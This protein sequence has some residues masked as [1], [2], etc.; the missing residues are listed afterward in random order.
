MPWPLSLTEIWTVLAARRTLIEIDA[1]LEAEL[2]GVGD[3][4]GESACASRPAIAADVQALVRRRRR[5]GGGRP[6]LSLSWLLAT[7]AWT[8]LSI[9]D[10][11]AH[12][13]DL[14]LG[15]AGDVDQLLDQPAEPADLA[16][17]DLAQ[18]DQDRVAAARACAARWR[19]WR[20][21]PADCAARARAS[22]GTGP[23]AAR[24]GAAPGCARR[25]SP[26]ASCARGCRARCRRSRPGRRR[27]RSAAAVVENPAVLAVVAAQPQVEGERRFAPRS[28]WRGCR[29]SARGPRD[30]RGG[31][32]RRR[33]TRLRLGRCRWLQDGLNQSLRCDRARRSRCRPGAA[34]ISR[35][36]FGVGRRRRRGSAGWLGFTVS[37][38]SAVSPTLR[39]ERRLQTRRQSACR[40]DRLADRHTLQSGR[41][42]GCATRAGARPKAASA[43]GGTW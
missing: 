15:G 31:S 40:D 25:A 23:G 1:G 18:A 21:A 14:A 35:D 16:F 19:R 7:A 39:D 42:G 41:R 29:G 28:W 20:S 34:A 10:R 33:A 24:P 9:D 13:R 37:A 22:P 5:R 17:E 8:T 2:G 12:Q 30:G 32:S 38:T 3:Q 43:A 11:L 6:A 4:V 26:R 36:P 27:R